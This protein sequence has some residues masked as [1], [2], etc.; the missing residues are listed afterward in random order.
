MTSP[1]TTDRERPGWDRASRAAALFCAALAVLAAFGLRWWLLREPTTGFAA[2]LPGSDDP[3][4]RRERLAKAAKAKAADVKIGEFFQPFEGTP[5]TT[6]ESWPCFRGPHYDHISRTPLAINTTW[7]D[8]GPP[9]RWS[10]QL[11]EGYA[12]AAVHNGRVYV[13]D[14]DETAEGDA[15]RCFSLTD[16]REIWRRWYK[17]PLRPNHG[18]SRTVPAVTDK[19]VVTLGPMA[20]VMCVDAVTGAL[21]WTIDMVRDYGTREDLPNMW[22]A[23]QCP[24]I[25]DGVAVLAPTGPNVLMMGVDCESG[26]TVW[27]TP[28]PAG[29]LMA[30]SSITP[31][32]LAGRRM[33][34]L[35]AI[36]GTVG[37]AADGPDRGRILWQSS[38]WDHRCVAPSPVAAGDNR[39]FLT[40]GYGKGCMMIRVSKDAG[41]YAV[42]VLYRMSPKEGPACEQHTPI[43][44]RDHL[45]TVQPD[46][47]PL[48][49]Q[50]VCYRPD[51]TLVWSSGKRNR[52]G[53]GPFMIADEKLLVLNDYGVLTVAQA[54]PE[55]YI[56]LAR[57]RV[58]DG[59]EAWAPFALVD[60]LLLLRDSE[61]MI[62]LD[63]R[64]ER[65]RPAESG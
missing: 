31:M 41:G 18:F 42:S 14:Y 30:H 9:V 47:G 23:S 56:Q 45:F 49:K 7:P 17:L 61:R 10:V 24:L 19:Y 46:E 11:G 2:S 28:N 44:Y 21:R 58:L 62:C 50:L 36:G 4:G 52:F 37:V 15:L 51:G 5:G 8:G 60:G 34:V 65:G 3:Y 25:E 6:T 35:C 55:R 1:G 33:Y 43:V 64:T 32:T 54:S 63:L 48:R 22:Y 20:H 29:W 57:A 16:G 12:G 38:E 26:Q 27:S 40:A 59:H 13:L 39:V 53:L